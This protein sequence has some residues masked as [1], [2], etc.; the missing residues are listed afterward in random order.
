[1][2]ERT[3]VV[4][5]QGG[6]QVLLGS[7]IKVGDD[8]PDCTLVANDLSE[9]ALSSYKGK[10]VVLSAVPSLDTPVCDVQTRKFNE[11]ATN[12]GDN[13]AVVTVS[14][15]LPFAQGRWC[16]AAGVENVVT[17]SDYRD[18]EFGKKYGVLL[19]GLALLTRAVFVVDAQ[20]DV[21]YTQ[22]VS[23]ITDEPDYDAVLAA[24]KELV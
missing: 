7:E 13:V 11:V 19:K 15:D 23:E 2:E 16:G 21:R 12:L 10:V 5:F 6:P 14:V 3:G 4:T 20:G 8:A 18:A 1:M 17:L 9:V 24:V 22:V